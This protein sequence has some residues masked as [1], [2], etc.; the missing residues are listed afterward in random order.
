MTRKTVVWKSVVD[1]RTGKPFKRRYHVN[2]PTP[3]T[4]GTLEDQL[5]TV[6]QERE[7]VERKMAKEYEKI[8]ELAAERKKLRDEQNTL[9]DALRREKP[10]PDYIHDREAFLELV[11]DY[12]NESKE[13]GKELDHVFSVHP[14]LRRGG[15]H[16][17]SNIPIGKLWMTRNEDVGSLTEHARDILTLTAT[18]DGRQVL[19]VMEHTLS[20]SGVYEVRNC[21]SEGDTVPGDQD[22]Y[23]VTK[24][25]Y[26]WQRILHTGTLESVLQYVSS[27]AWYTTEEGEFGG[28]ETEYDEDD[29]DYGW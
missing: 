19:S 14:S 26:G 21:D 15:D 11:A 4:R 6:T 20:E 24:T 10:K 13:A 23:S 3:D 17:D 2:A 9:K 16:R 7:T 1:P 29:E 28:K 18:D 27:N 5:N 12:F 22:V 25:S 8:A